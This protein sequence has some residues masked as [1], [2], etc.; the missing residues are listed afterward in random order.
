MI[1]YLWH[2]CLNFLLHRRLHNSNLLI[3]S[4]LVHLLLTFVWKTVLP[5][6]A[7]FLFFCLFLPTT[8]RL[9][10]IA[11]WLE[12][13]VS[14]IL[15]TFSTANALVFIHAL[16]STMLAIPSLPWDA[17]STN[18]FHGFK[19]LKNDWTRDSEERKDAGHEIKFNKITVQWCRGLGLRIKVEGHIIYSLKILVDILKC[20]RSR[21]GSKINP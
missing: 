12:I 14:D 8:V 9:I 16:T 11:L 20:N 15:L 13:S 6:Q 21:K 4:F 19:R 17:L 1:S 7:F 10:T 18:F 2:P 3:L 5:F